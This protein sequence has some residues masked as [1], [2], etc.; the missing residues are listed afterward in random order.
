MAKSKR[1]TRNDDNGDYKAADGYINMPA[2]KKW[3]LFQ[4]TVLQ[5]IQIVISGGEPTINRSWIELLE[6]LH[7]NGFAAPV[8]Y[9]NGLN[10]KDLLLCETKPEKLCKIMLTHHFDSSEQKTKDLAEFMRDLGISFLVKGLVSETDDNSRFVKSLNAP[11]VIEG[12]KKPMPAK[13]EEFAKIAAENSPLGGDNKYYWRWN[14]YG[15]RINRERFKFSLDSYILTIDVTGNIFNCHLF[16]TPVGNIYKREELR[17]LQMAGC[18]YLDTINLDKPEECDIR[19]EILHY[20]KLF[21]LLTVEGYMKN[22][23][24]MNFSTLPP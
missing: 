15:D 22:Y 1:E 20:A 18:V 16:Q 23:L 13:F 4:K 9:T 2:L 24:K 21:K 14:G 17:G 8:V 19:C 6:W 5:D 3:L 12:I 7:L 10:V 11:C